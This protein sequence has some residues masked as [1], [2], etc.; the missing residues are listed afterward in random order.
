MDGVCS[1][2]LEDTSAT[3]P[4][5]G[6]GDSVGVDRAWRIVRFDGYPR[7]QLVMV[8]TLGAFSARW[9]TK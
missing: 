8:D 4:D 6:S 7:G 1:L 9:H 3:P 2:W 5:A